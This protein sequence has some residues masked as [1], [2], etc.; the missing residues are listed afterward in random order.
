[1]PDGAVGACL[2]L[3]PAGCAAAAAATGLWKVLLPLTLQGWL[4][5][6]ND[7][8]NHAVAPAGRWQCAAGLPRLLHGPAV[9]PGLPW[10]L[11][12]V[13]GW[14]GRQARCPFIDKG[15]QEIGE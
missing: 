10:R 12:M 6:G 4:R 14:T 3:A 11:S 8:V 2:G 9:A 13:L 7:E 1:M 5:G 15:T